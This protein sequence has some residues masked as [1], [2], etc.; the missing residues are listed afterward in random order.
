MP[1][2]LRHGGRPRQDDHALGS[3]GYFEHRGRTKT[4]SLQACEKDNGLKKVQQSVEE[5]AGIAAV[6]SAVQEQKDQG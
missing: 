3:P 4:P 1:T 6:A 2:N 5:K